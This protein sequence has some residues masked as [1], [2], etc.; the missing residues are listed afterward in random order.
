[1]AWSNSSPGRE[2]PI[3]VILERQRAQLQ[4]LIARQQVIVE[5]LQRLQ[6]RLKDS[7]SASSE[8]WFELLQLMQL[9]DRYFSP[10]ELAL[11]RS[12]AR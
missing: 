11:F 6:G 2:S 10:K 9:Q 8:E 7:A 12:R 1:V 3:D 5:K 4:E